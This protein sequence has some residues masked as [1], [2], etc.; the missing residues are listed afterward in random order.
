M[1]RVSQR[2][3]LIGPKVTAVAAHEALESQMPPGQFYDYHVGVIR[4][5]RRVCKAQ[6]PRCDACVLADACPS[7][8]SF[9]TPAP[10]APRKRQKRARA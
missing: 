7:A 8:F 5:G 9:G 4:H 1:H 2:L 3:G 6:R 10:A